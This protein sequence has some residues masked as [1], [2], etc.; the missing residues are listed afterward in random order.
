[1]ATTLRRALIALLSAAFCVAA[2]AADYQ[3]VVVKPGD[4]LWSIA[5][6][7]LQ[8][9]TKWDE[10]VKYNKSLSSDPTVALPGMTLNV[11]TQ[12]LKEE[13]RAARLVT[14]VNTVLFRRSATAAWKPGTSNMELYRNDWIRTL[15]DSSASVRFLDDDL[16]RLGANSMAVIKPVNKDYAVEIK[17]G[18]TFIGRAKIV[19]A[20]AVVTPHSKDTRYV[21]TVRDD[22]STKVEVLRGEALVAAAGRTVSV[23][24]GMVSEIAM[25]LAPSVPVKIADMPAFE[26]RAVEL[27]GGL[28]AGLSRAKAPA[29]PVKNTGALPVADV[30]APKS[31][32]SELKLGSMIS[33]YRIQCSDNQDISDLR[34]NKSVDWDEN[35]SAEFLGIPPG[36]YWCRVAPLDLLGVAQKFTSPRQYLLK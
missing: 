29:V 18:G 15:D 28:L 10:L 23:K 30:S 3:T 32:L 4:T 5:N 1:M 27:N 35:V 2:H 11:P 21:A 26:A 25:G 8:D 17:R 24:T 12:M 36:R 22:M 9:P 31:A 34:V 16:L 20:G 33:G 7:Y 19:T 6:K 14:R 13:L